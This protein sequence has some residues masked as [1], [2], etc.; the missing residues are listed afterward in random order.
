MIE[1]TLVLI[2]PDGI[3]AGLEN[4]IKERLTATGLEIV[5]EKVEQADAAMA[6]LHYDDLD[7]RKSPEIKQIMVD[8]LSSGSVEALIV[9]GENAIAETRRIIGATEPISADKG[10]IRG[11]LATDSYNAA[12][13]ENRALLN[14]VHASDSPENAAREIQLWFP[15]VA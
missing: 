7:V 10:T 2:K 9:E 3:A 13:G 11:D 4:E 6:S 5:A 15:E 12:N 1:R 14:L 8:F